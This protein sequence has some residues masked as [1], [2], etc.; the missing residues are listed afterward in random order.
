MGNGKLPNLTGHSGFERKS[1]KN[2]EPMKP[3]G[4][5][6]QM[7]VDEDDEDE[8]EDE[9]EVEVEVEVEEEDEDD[10]DSDDSFMLY[11][12]GLPSSWGSL[13]SGDALMFRGIWLPPNT[14]EAAHGI[15]NELVKTVLPQCNTVL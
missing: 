1:V 10:N 2:V 7:G 4:A 12:I 11:K 5:K 8:D 15:Y 13:R 6:S 9:D 3:P 14:E